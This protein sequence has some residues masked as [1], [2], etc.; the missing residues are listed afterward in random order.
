MGNKIV[1]EEFIIKE[2][3]LALLER[4]HRHSPAVLLNGRP[5][6]TGTGLYRPDTHTHQLTHAR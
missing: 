6:S 4:K 1:G 5:I 2:E 3:R